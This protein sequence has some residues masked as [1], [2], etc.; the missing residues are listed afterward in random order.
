MIC[1]RCCESSTSISPV[2]LTHCV[3][4]QQRRILHR[5]LTST[6]ERAEADYRHVYEDGAGLMRFVADLGMP[7]PRIFQVTAEFVIN[8]ELRRAF[9][10]EELDLVRVAMLLEAAKR[11]GITLDGSG[12][13]YT[14]REALDRG[15]GRLL[16]RLEV[17][18]A[19]KMNAAIR[20]V[21]MLP[22]EVNLWRVQ[23]ECYDGLRLPAVN[24]NPEL[25]RE[26]EGLARN[27]RIAPE[28]VERPAREAQPEP[29]LAA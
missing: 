24:A 22:F 3:R 14:L 9:E 21:R 28:A 12:L 25:L 2:P 15:M 4:D 16:S 27:L 23:N 17:R 19:Q 26:W 6:L 11:D 1:P 13:G 5:L 18:E 10:K 8:A 7:Q 29:V 20:L